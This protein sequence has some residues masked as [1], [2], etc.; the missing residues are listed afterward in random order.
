MD[1][2]STPE[3]ENGPDARPPAPA[4]T[5]DTSEPVTASTGSLERD[6]RAASR[7]GRYALA[8]ALCAAIVS[9]AVSAGSAVYV[10]RNELVRNETVAVAKEVRENRQRVYADLMTGVIE[11][12]EGLGYLKGT[13]TRNPPDRETVRAAFDDLSEKGEAA[14]KTV[15]MVFLVGS[16]QLIP[17]LDEFTNP[18]HS[19][20]NDQVN[21]FVL[22]NFGGASDVTD[23]DGLLRDGPGL[24]AE[25][26]R[27]VAVT[28]DFLGNFVVRGRE[29]L[30]TG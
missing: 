24:I 23:P 17:T 30:E 19:F 10:S 7:T 2:D 6:I 12:L 18:Y 14:I 25:I 20:V 15:N 27:I 13:L 8:T 4:P 3:P 5:S 21:P 11:Y 22:R 1:T 16:M 29:D 9:S 28:G 26:D